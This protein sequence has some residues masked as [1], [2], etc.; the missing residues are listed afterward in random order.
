MWL[1]TW[2]KKKTGKWVSDPEGP[3]RTKRDAIKYIR[4]VEDCLLDGNC[5]RLYQC[6]QIA[7]P[8]SN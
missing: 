4:D 1:I 8:R 7:F 6:K 3:F 5:L 2:E